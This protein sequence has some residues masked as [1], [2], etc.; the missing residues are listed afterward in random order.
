MTKKVCGNW[1]LPPPPLFQEKLINIFSKRGGP[2]YLEFLEICILWHLHSPFRRVGVWYRVVRF[3]WANL[4]LFSTVAIHLLHHVGT[5][6]ISWGYL[7]RLGW[8][9]QSFHVFLS[10]T[11]PRTDPFRLR[12]TLI[13]TQRSHRVHSQR[14]H[15]QRCHQRSVPTKFHTISYSTLYL[16]TFLVKV[17]F[18]TL[19]P[20]P[21]DEGGAAWGLNSSYFFDVLRHLLHFVFVFHNAHENG[22]DWFFVFRFFVHISIR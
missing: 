18:K 12:M 21:I 19:P 11:R 14:K 8:W 5:L 6:G 17:T 15:H 9:D 16:V 1:N 20:L 13:D 7:H 4:Q 10:T 22:F 2:P 3:G